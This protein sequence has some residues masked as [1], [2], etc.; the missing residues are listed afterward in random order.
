MCSERGQEMAEPRN[1]WE[2]EQNLIRLNFDVEKTT[3]PYFRNLRLSY[4]R[5]EFRSLR[6]YLLTRVRIRNRIF[7]LTFRKTRISIPS[8]SKPP[9]SLRARNRS[10][11]ARRG[12]L[13][14]PS[15]RALLSEFDEGKLTLR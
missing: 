5:T 11:G 3:L 10:P 2:S 1:E 14:S 7:G 4:V 12:P 13:Q 9:P 6:P 15:T 8:F